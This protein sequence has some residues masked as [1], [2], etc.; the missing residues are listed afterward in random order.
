MTRELPLVT[1]G[2]AT[3]NG[4][5]YLRSSLLSVLHGN[6]KNIEVLVLDDGSSDNS[7]EIASAIGDSRL[8]VIR[9]TRNEGLVSARNRIMREANGVYLAWLDQDDIAYPDRLVRQV[10]ALEAE[11]QVGAY[12]TWTMYRTHEP[13]GEEWLRHIPMPVDHNLIRATVPFNNPLSF[14]TVTMR[15]SMFAD[16]QLEFRPAFG[17][18]LDYDMWSRAA[19]V[20]ELRSLP[21]YLGE[22]RL[23]PNQTSRGDAAYAMSE[24][25]WVVQAEAL[26]RNLGIDVGVDSQHIHRQM[27]GAPWTIE[28]KARLREVG[29]WL[30]HLK[31]TNTAKRIYAQRPFGQAIARQW[32]RALWYTNRQ[33][34][35]VGALQLAAFPHKAAGLAYADIMNGGRAAIHGKPELALR[36]ARQKIPFRMTR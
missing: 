33:I 1:V 30:R 35:A 29:H 18:C 4:E 27:T 25:A 22:Y 19:D 11:P 24:S 20:M 2:V 9:N 23:H 5:A 6:Y 10:S 3:Y 31:E 12:G 15:L 21:E 8:T 32:V 13:S 16:C 28:S 36:K 7:I 26:L 14:N 17:N 34:G